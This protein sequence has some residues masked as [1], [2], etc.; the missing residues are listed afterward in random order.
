MHGGWPRGAEATKPELEFKTSRPV[1]NLKLYAAFRLGHN[2][3][4]Y[5]SR[6]QKTDG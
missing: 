2:C 1:E 4:K 3:E 6:L 5:Q